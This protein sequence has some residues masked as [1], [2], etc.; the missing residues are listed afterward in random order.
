MVSLF[1]KILRNKEGNAL[2]IAGAALP[3]VVGAAGL[4]SDTIQWTLWK[5]QLQR[6][7]DSAAIAG[8]YSRMKT[9]SEN[10]VEGGV[11]KDL[12]RDNHVW[13][14]LRSSDFPEVELLDDGDPIADARDGVQVTLEI[15]QRLPFSSM[16]L[17]AAPII[18]ATAT[19]AT[20]PLGD[21]YCVI[22]TDP[23]GVGI[24]ITGST[25]L[26]F[27]DCSLIANSDNPKNA[28]SNGNNGAGG[29]ASKITARSLAAVGQIAKSSQW[30][31][32]HYNPSAT[33]AEDH[34][35]DLYKQLPSSTA[36]TSTPTKC[37][38]NITMTGGNEDRS[39]KDTVSSDIICITNVDKKGKPTGLTI[40][41]TVKLGKGTYIVNG[42]DLTMNATGTK[43]SC[44]ACTMVMSKLG[45]ATNTGSVKLTGGTVDINA[46]DVEGETWRGIA[47][48]QDPRAKDDGKTGT[49]QI[50][51]NSKGGVSG[52]V[53]FGNQSLLWNGGGNATAMCLQMVAKRV[54]FSG[55][56]KF[57]MI[58]GVDC[59]YD[60][61]GGEPA[62]RRVRLVG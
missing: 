16:F 58:G 38:K 46:P 49:N 13:M 15:Q 36:S 40:S 53:Y 9:D 22:G 18:R 24:E 32:D 31:I 35:W 17:S 4:A 29:A 34:Y 12:A 39:A 55:N 62:T 41:G 3:L 61:V 2:L 27:G 43:L 19:A 44:E 25:E 50:N 37:T 48:Y 42:G 47:F 21:N 7:A 30:D 8:V 20:V 14:G 11:N 6:A 28:A 33:A 26:D 10:S 1:K 45:D 5:R 54:T 23:H 59:P 51:G 56:S 52:V 57:Q 60:G